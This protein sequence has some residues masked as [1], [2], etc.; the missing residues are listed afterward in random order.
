MD[1]PTVLDD[2]SR[3]DSA[4]ELHKPKA[5]SSAGT[6]TPKNRILLETTSCPAS[7]TDRVIY[8]GATGNLYY[9]ADGTGRRAQVLVAT[10]GDTV[11]PALA[12]DDLLVMA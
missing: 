9:D 8:D 11:H 4:T 3:C 5:R 10:I 2:L 12:F 1:L 7:A 6:R